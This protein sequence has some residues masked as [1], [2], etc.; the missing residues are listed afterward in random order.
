MVDGRYRI[1]SQPPIVVP[2]RD[3]APTHRSFGRRARAH[4][5]RT[6]PRLPRN[7]AGRSTP[8]AGALRSR[9]HGPQGRRRRQRR[10]ARV[11]RVAPRS[12]SR[13]TRCSCRSRRR[14]RR[15][16]RT[17]CRRVSYA[18]PGERV[19]QGQRMMQAASDIF[20]GW[21][22][23]AQD[24]PLPVL[25]PVARHEGFGG[26]RDDGPAGARRSTRASAVRRWPG[27]MP[28]PATRSRSPRISAR[29]IA[30]T[31]RSPTSPNATPTRTQQDYQAFV[32]AI[33]SGR[34]EA[35]QGV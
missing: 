4:D 33:G 23:G 19:V 28:D 12:R 29:R 30:S 9:R 34:L 10:H 17:T 7:L 2:L 31:S 26:R 32:D 18:Q 1:V 22:K 3:L 11:H 8:A 27:R 13:A 15:C 21:T 35:I 14:R 20:L 25:A 6:V 5:P 24:G 16:S